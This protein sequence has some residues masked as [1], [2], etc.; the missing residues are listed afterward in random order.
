MKIIVQDPGSY[1][2]FFYVLAFA[3][4][5]MLFVIFSLRQ[6]IALFPVLLMMTAVSFCTILGSR[7]F[8]TP[9][10]EWGNILSDGNSAVFSGRHAL[11]GLLS[12]LAGLALSVR[13]LALD[14]K[15]LALYAWITPLG[16][17]I[18]KAGCLMNGC[19]FGK[20]TD[21]PWGLQ[22]PAGT[23]AHYTH[24]SSGLIKDIAGLSLPVHPVQLYEMILL[25]LISYIVWRTQKVWTRKWSPVLSGLCLFALARFFTAFFRDPAASDIQAIVMPGFSLVQCLLVAMALVTGIILF[26]SEKKHEISHS[27]PESASSLKNPLLFILILSALIYIVRGIFTPFEL[28]SLSI[29]FV[30]AI[31]FAAIFVF[32]SAGSFRSRVAAGTLLAGPLFLMS[33]SFLPDTIKPGLVGD[34][35]N[36]V[37]SYKRLDLDM[38]AGDFYST[39][40]FDPHEGQC[41]TVYTQEDYR[42][43]YRMGGAGISF[44]S[45][46][47]KAITSTGINLYGGINKES[48]LT[49][50]WERKDFLFGINPYYNYD[51]KWVG[52]GFGAHFGNL[53]WASLSPIDKPSYDRGTRFSPLM[54]G[55]MLRIGRKDIIDVQ[56]SYGF[57]LPAPIP[58]M[59]HQ[60]SIGTGLG[61]KTDYSLRLGAALSENY[62][63]IFL[64]AEAL[65]CKNL[66]LTFKYN[67]GGDDFYFAYPSTDFVDRKGRIQFGANYRFGYKK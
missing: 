5:F 55:L 11:G 28:L 21:L 37:K 41:G 59:L 31:I 22:Y 50:Q 47:E 66:G 14:K 29:R 34:S 53:R 20:V 7:L 12:G 30:P 9:V 6:K 4:T 60:V 10:Q 3:V 57:D 49:K 2:F 40:M 45:I 8:T 51:L 64:S 33:H 19:C 44:I 61:Y 38:S 58:V 46:K 52:I 23:A 42:H 67:F 1:F 36:A 13:V 25:L 27:L 17:G 32:R 15:T 26:L 39:T 63:T 65:L 43:I 18:Q 56:Y 48:N 35:Y 24:F 62:A 54:P 16:F